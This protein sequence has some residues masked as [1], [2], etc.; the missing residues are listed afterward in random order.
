MEIFLIGVLGGLL[1]LDAT[2]VGQ[3][4]ISRPLV[5]GVLAGVVVDQPL[6]GATI[7]AILELYLLVSFPAGGSQ[8]P[9]GAT[10]TVVAVASSAGVTGSG[11]LPL[12]IG[13]GLVWGQLGGVS[14]TLLRQANSKIV[15]ERRDTV[16]GVSW[17][18]RR[19]LSAIALDFFRGCLVTVSGV[20]LGRVGL[21]A[22]SASWPL[23]VPSSIGHLLVGGSVSAGIFLR[24]LGGFRQRRTLFVVGMA[25]GIIGS[26]VL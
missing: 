10:A 8:F 16:S 25:L 12:A 14:V 2:S 18:V 11:V 19:H 26:R 17:V 24:D 22:L 13:L 1:A 15:E 3:F 23:E 9:E 21:Q 7:G 6:L 20:V 5:G 4:M